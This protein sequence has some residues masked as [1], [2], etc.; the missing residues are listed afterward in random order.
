MISKELRTYYESIGIPLKWHSKTLDDFTNDREALRVIRKYIKN[1]KEAF[2]DGV[3]FF[4]TGKNGVGKTHLLMCS[5]MELFNLRH[6]VQVISLSALVDMYT[7]SWYDAEKREELLQVMIKK[8]FLGIEEI[9]KQFSSEKSM[10]V[11]THILE[12][13]LRSRLQHNRPT[14][15]TSNLTA[16]SMKDVYNED[17]ASMLRE[18]AVPLLVEGND[19]RG[20]YAEANKKRWLT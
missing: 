14:W 2:K 1:H 6:S 19:K 8:H 5:F 10:D 3:G 20:D 17:I 7:G 9:G 11:V 15:F 18:C 13:V 16:S 12:V 4:L